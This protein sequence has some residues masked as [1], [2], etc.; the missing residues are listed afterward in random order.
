MGTLY[1]ALLLCV[2]IS[3]DLKLENL[4]LTANGYLKL[5]DFGLCKGGM[6]PNDRTST[7]CGTPEFVAPEMITDASYTRVIDWW[8]LGVL[9]Y[10]MIVGKVSDIRQQ[11]E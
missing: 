1:D 4:L 2:Q 3:R 6:G 5:A 8:S 10:E 9:I 11:F 7:F